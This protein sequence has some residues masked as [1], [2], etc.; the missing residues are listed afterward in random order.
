[1]ATRAIV[2]CRRALRDGSAEAA[3]RTAPCRA[4][5]VEKLKACETAVG[6]LLPLRTLYFFAGVASL[7]LTALLF[8]LGIGVPPAL[9]AALE[10][11]IRGAVIATDNVPQ[12]TGLTGGVRV[13][14]RC[15]CWRAAWAPA[16]PHTRCV[17]RRR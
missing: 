2:T 12:A 5:C 1:M 16:T 15:A 14:E 6:R 10:Q 7:G 4:S 9:A 8:V 11:D 13:H 17:A 3:A